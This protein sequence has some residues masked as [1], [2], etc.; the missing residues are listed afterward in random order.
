MPEGEKNYRCP[1]E[2]E[3]VHDENSN[4]QIFNLLKILISSE[5]IAVLNKGL[6]FVPI[7]DLNLFQWVKNI[8]LFAR[9]LA[10]KKEYKDKPSEPI[11]PIT[12][13]DI[14]VFRILARRMRGWRG[15]N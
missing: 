3:Q 12:S 9:K 7:Q 8:N 4:L 14:E 13:K 11:Q 1:P 2:S 15:R 10:L 6:S 5:H